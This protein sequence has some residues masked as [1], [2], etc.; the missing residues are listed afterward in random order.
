[1]GLDARVADG[2]QS[3]LPPPIAPCCVLG[4]RAVA[5]RDRAVKLCDKAVNAQIRAAYYT[6][7]ASRAISRSMRLEAVR[8]ALSS[9]A[10]HSALA[11]GPGLM[12]QTP[13]C[14]RRVWQ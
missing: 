11:R 10:I 1:V 2:H 3:H 9:R 4:S 7:L 6:S 8:H 13:R 5:A 12:D 14:C